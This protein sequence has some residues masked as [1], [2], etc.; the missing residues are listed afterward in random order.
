MKPVMHWPL[1]C[2]FLQIKLF[3][4]IAGA[5][6]VWLSI[7]CPNP[8]PTPSLQSLVTFAHQPSTAERCSQC[9]QTFGNP[10]QSCSPETRLCCVILSGHVTKGDAAMRPPTPDVHGKDQQITLHDLLYW[11]MNKNPG[12][13]LCCCEGKFLWG[14]RTSWWLSVCI[15]F[16]LSPPCPSW[17]A[18]LARHGMDPSK[19]PSE[20][21]HKWIRI[22][23]SPPCWVSGLVGRQSLHPPPATTQHP[24]AQASVPSLGA[25]PHHW[26]SWHGPDQ[27]DLL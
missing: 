2:Q 7:S 10:S 20:P 14:F 12:E 27:L 8:P 15:S 26:P 6:F 22:V 4:M 5:I 17:A 9:S 13:L 18:S 23:L 21:P 16:T 11:R 19:K 25:R 3:C 24:C 1:I